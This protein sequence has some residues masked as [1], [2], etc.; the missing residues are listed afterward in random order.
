MTCLSA[1]TVSEVQIKFMWGLSFYICSW[2]FVNLPNVQVKMDNRQHHPE[3]RKPTF[4]HDLLSN[5]KH[6]A[7][8]MVSEMCQNNFSF[9]QN[10]I[11]YINAINCWTVPLNKLKLRSCTYL[12][13]GIISVIK[14]ISVS[15]LLLHSAE[16]WFEVK[17]GW[18]G[19]FENFFWKIHW[20]E[21][22]RFDDGWFVLES[23]VKIEG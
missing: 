7:F 1:P 4:N 15:V 14:E 9:T 10:C 20:S 19:T 18:F 6:T 22:L 12:H 17:F 16:M 2:A 21:S 3:R 13:V 8:E 23:E 5:W 11:C